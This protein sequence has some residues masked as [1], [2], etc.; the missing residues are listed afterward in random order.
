MKTYSVWIEVEEHD[1]DTDE[2]RDCEGLDFASVA[3]FTDE[4]AAFSLANRLQE[5][6]EQLAKESNAQRI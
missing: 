3:T 6:G 4:G 1:Q 5:T 2:Y